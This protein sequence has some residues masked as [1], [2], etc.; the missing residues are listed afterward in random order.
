VSLLITFNHAIDA[1]IQNNPKGPAN[2]KAVAAT[3]RLQEA[4]HEFSSGKSSAVRDG[5]SCE[6]GIDSGDYHGDDEPRWDRARKPAND[7]LASAEHGN[8]ADQRSAQTMR[9]DGI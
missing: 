6:T 4:T 7:P 3:G 2:P 1:V 9:I 5:K 8:E